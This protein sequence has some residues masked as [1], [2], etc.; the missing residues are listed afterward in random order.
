MN[1]CERIV[2]QACALAKEENRLRA[3]WDKKYKK[4]INRHDCLSPVGTQHIEG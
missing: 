2:E 3:T 1:L 4:S